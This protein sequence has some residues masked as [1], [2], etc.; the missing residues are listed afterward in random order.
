MQITLSL[1][2]SFIFI[3]LAG[4]H[5]YWASGGRRGFEE[6]LPTDE[7]GKKMMIEPSPLACVVVGL[8]LLLFGSY[9]LLKSGLVE[10]DVPEWIMTY[11]G[12]IIPAIFLFRAIG[13]FKYAGFFKRVKNTE[14]GKRDTRFYAPLC[15]FIGVVGVLLQ[16]MG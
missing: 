15:L 10:V 11:G 5:F 14:F 1:L 8:G 2:L 3:I 6:A 7:K 4:V 13:D 16:L 12:W 9:Y